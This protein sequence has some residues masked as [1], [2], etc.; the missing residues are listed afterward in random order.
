MIVHSINSKERSLATLFILSAIEI[1]LLASATAMAT[2]LTIKYIEFAVFFVPLIVVLF[3]TLPTLE[4]IK[5][6]I[7][8]YISIMA[9]VIRWLLALTSFIVTFAVTD[10]ILA[11][12]DK[13]AIVELTKEI[14]HEPY[15]DTSLAMIF[16]GGLGASWNQSLI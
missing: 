10:I 15:F 7:P 9:N 5:L 1:V 16:I 3:T 11:D 8:G 13:V 2:S 12:E 4:K 6:P 14:P